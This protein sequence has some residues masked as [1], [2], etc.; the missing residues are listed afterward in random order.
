MYAVPLI[1]D[2][3]ELLSHRQRMLLILVLT[4]K[5]LIRP[6]PLLTPRVYPQASKRGFEMMCSVEVAQVALNRDFGVAPVVQFVAQ[7]AVKLAVDWSKELG[8]FVRGKLHG[9]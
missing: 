6:T 4:M 8:S 5:T 7:V 9:P 3:V 1:I 2:P